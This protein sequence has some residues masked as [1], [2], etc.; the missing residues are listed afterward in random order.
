MTKPARRRSPAARPVATDAEAKALA[1]TLRMR[2]LRVCL[3]DA[4]TNKEIADALGKDPATTLHHV[5]RLV[6]AGFLA[7]QPMRRGVRGSREIPYLA[8]G[9][10]WQLQVPAK[11]HVLL[12]AFLEEIELVPV[13]SLETSRLGLRLDEGTH[14]EFL[15]RLMELFEEF[16]IRSDEARTGE[17]WSIFFAMHPDPNQG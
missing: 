15:D 12:G 1:S 3:Y 2:I 5:R 4:R 14:A 17:A 7:S 8:T 6:D 16:R 10:S 9:K 11:N 13:E